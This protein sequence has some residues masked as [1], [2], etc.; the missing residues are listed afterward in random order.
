VNAA[1]CDSVVSL[2]LTINGTPNIG[3]TV[4]SPTLIAQTPGLTYQWVDCNNGYAPIAGET[5]QIFTAKKNGNYAVIA[6]QNGCADTSNC[7]LIPTTGIAE[8]NASALLQAYPNPTTGRFTAKLS[9]EF[10][11]VTVSVMNLLWQEVYRKELDVAS[12]LQVDLEGPKGVYFI[13]V[14]SKN[15][16]LARLKVL[17]Q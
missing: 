15:E 6:T 4:S 16:L 12:A 3:V 13:T 5:N 9:K 1:G 2:N 14:S 8:N 11:D 10:K 17:K 7:Y